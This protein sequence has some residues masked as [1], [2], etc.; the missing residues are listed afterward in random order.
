[1]EDSSFS[2]VKRAF[3]SKKKGDIFIISG[4]CSAESPEQL[5]ETCL[6]L[7]KLNIDLIRAGIWKPRTRPGSFEGF[8]SVALEWLKNAGNACAL[9]VAV[10]V[11]KPSHVE[12]CLRAGI[13][14]LWIGARTTVNPFLVQEIADALKGT[15][16][17]IMVKNPV[18]PDLD[19]W[20][21]AIERIE[22][23]GIS[24]I[25]AIHRGFST[26][27]KTMYRNKPRWEIPVELK[28]RMPDIPLICDPSHICGNTTWISAISQTAIDLSFD[29]LMIESHIHPES[30]LSDKS[31]QLTP[32]ALKNI[33]E[34]LIYRRP[35]I[36]DKNLLSGIESLR[37]KI[38]GIDKELIEILSKRMNT[39]RKIGE[40]KLK[41]NATIL[42]RVRWDEIIKSRIETGSEK[43]L[44]EHF[45]FQ[46]FEII[47]QEAIN[48]QS[49][50]MNKK[51]DL[52]NF[53]S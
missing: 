39:A 3:F 10:E 36:E 25:A 7:S 18:N 53:V 9:P 30:A 21:G 19:L 5:L 33:L 44:S 11:A 47:H 14:V 31:Q 17:K 22:K 4:P 2:N 40:Y 52:D 29:G 6:Q 37:D 35:D 45:I 46:L 16:V 41:G 8:G 48:Q 23:S 38:D 26:Y 20:I 27:E 1:M 24:D 50:I 34:N 32:S 49:D 42:Q 13:D 12:E 28:R 51:N 15:K 43:N